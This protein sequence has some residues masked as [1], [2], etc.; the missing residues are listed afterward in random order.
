[1]N[2][3]WGRSR[4]I[5]WRTGHLWGYDGRQDVWDRGEVMLGELA[6]F[7]GILGTVIVLIV[8]WQ[9]VRD[10]GRVCGHWATSCP[11]MGKI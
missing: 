9:R 6:A 5:G 10:A 8:H 4:A 11:T 3:L 1:M 2:G 7:A